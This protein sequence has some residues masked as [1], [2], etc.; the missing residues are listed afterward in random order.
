MVRE[1]DDKGYIKFVNLGGI[2]PRVLCGR[3]VTLGDEDRRVSGVIASKAI[4]HQKPDER[5]VST[6]IDKMYIDI[7]ATSREEAEQYVSV[8][9]FGTFDSDFEIFGEG[10]RLMKGK[11]ID[12]RLGCTVM[13]EVMRAIK[14]RKIRPSHDLYFAFTVREEVGLSG[15]EVTANRIAP[16]FAIVLESTAIA[17]IADVAPRSRVAEVGEGGVI[18]LLD[19]STIYDRAFVDFAMET[20][21]REGIPA[22]IKRYVS[23]G[24]DAGHIHKSGKGVRA[25]AISAATRYLHSASCV[26]AV[27][28]FESIRALVLALVADWRL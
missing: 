7:G 12:D 22:Q 13:I 4:H 8:G 5:L 10:G 25:L 16:D 26:A 2:D 23:G 1:I 14:D 17:D 19:R 11:A 15:A 18:S 9:D 21:E 3:H 28:D 27:R 20:A 6:P 24:N